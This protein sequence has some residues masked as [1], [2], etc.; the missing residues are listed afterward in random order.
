MND[1]TKV[2]TGKPK[3]T[4]AIWRAPFGST[5]PTNATAEL[6]AAFKCL[7]YCS[8]DGLTNNNSPETENIKAWGG[9][10]VLTPLTEK[11]DTFGY[12]LIEA[13]NVEVLKSVY[14]D[15]N[16]TGDLDTGITVRANSKD[17]DPSAYVIDQI[18]K[19]GILKRIVIPNATLSELSEIVYKDDEAVGYGVTLNAM[20]GGFADGDPDTHKEYIVKPASTE[21]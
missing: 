17:Q 2:T 3:V 7:G 11:L 10:V 16:V 15:A 21:G 14:G 8:E 19:G 18:F 13:I 1:V 5:L 20:T 9:D 6:D 4:G 12:T